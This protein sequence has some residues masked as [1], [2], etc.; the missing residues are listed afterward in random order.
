MKLYKG[1]KI[2]PRPPAFCSGLSGRG[3]NPQAS[4]ALGPERTRGPKQPTSGTSDHLAQEVVPA[5]EEC[6]RKATTNESRGVS[7][8]ARAS[9][10]GMAFEQHQHINTVRNLRLHHFIR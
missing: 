2:I 7:R 9:T 8:S 3:N 4:I 1:F 6:N 10:G 5:G